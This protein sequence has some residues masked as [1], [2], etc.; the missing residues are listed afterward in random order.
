MFK[1]ILKSMEE[2]RKDAIYDYSYEYWTK[3]KKVFI[4]NVKSPEKRSGY[5]EYKK[6]L[7]RSWNIGH[8]GDISLRPVTMN[9]EIMAYVVE[10]KLNT[11]TYW[12]RMYENY[13]K[14]Y[15]IFKTEL[16]VI[17]HPTFDHWFFDRHE[18]PIDVNSFIPAVK[19]L[20]AIIKLYNDPEEPEYKRL[21]DK[22]KN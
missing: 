15:N 4:P 17:D 16:N 18:T 9:N 1:D 3:D 19:K 21:I 12:D 8:S 20:Q 11:N 13:I 10:T 6:S 2:D 22:I 5:E 14:A 7:P